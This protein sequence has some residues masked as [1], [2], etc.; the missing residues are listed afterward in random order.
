MKGYTEDLDLIRDILAFKDDEI[1]WTTRTPSVFARMPNY[2][3]SAIVKQ[4]AEDYAK[5]VLEESAERWNAGPKPGHP[6]RWHKI[7]KAAKG[8]KDRMYIRFDDSMLVDEDI[9]EALGLTLEKVREI[10]GRSYKQAD[11]TKPQLKAARR[12]R[13]GRKRLAD[14]S[15]AKTTKHLYNAA[16]ERALKDNA[17]AVSDQVV[18]R[19]FEKGMTRADVQMLRKT[20]YKS[21]YSILKLG[22]MNEAETTEALVRH[23]TIPEGEYDGITS[24]D[25][26]AGQERGPA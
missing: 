3:Q 25:S 21:A 24:Q 15:P 13:Q 26:D 2:W 10:A 11:A 23:F 19:V 12:N 8:N 6:P 7:N 22:Q 16:K 14:L 1:V 4:G 9:A 18:L 20:A 5:D 17:R